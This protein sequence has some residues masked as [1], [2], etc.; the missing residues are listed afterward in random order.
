MSDQACLAWCLAGLGRVAA[1]AEQPACAAR[2]WGGA[3]R[4]RQVLGCRSAP[5]ARATYE[6]AMAVA[7]AQLGEAAFAT[8]WEG[9][10]A[11]TVEQAIV[12][13]VDGAAEAPMS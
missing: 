12:E 13:A 4:Q 1:L 6:H 2:L 9:G 3:E 5:A 8:A 7:R 11:L 10:R